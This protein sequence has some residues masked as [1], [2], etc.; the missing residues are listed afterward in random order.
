VI[1]GTALQAHPPAASAGVLGGGRGSRGV[2]LL[3]GKESESDI[4]R[5]YIHTIHSHYA[6]QL[7]VT[8]FLT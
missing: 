4:Q 8:R 7:S 1:I 6:A 5:T 3:M 2:I